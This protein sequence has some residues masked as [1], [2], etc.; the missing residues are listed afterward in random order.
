M[1]VFFHDKLKALRDAI[2][3]LDNLTGSLQDEPRGQAEASS[4]FGCGLQGASCNFFSLR[5]IPPENGT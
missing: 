1:S 2:A 5:Q 4:S 3:D